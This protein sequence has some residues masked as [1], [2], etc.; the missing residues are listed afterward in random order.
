MNKTILG[1]VY[2]AGLL[3]IA[4]CNSAEPPTATQRLS[5]AQF[6]ELY[7]SLRNAQDSARTSAEFDALKQ[8]ILE[9]AGATSESLSQ[10]AIEHTGQIAFMAEV[11]DSI[12]TRLDN[13][14]LGTPR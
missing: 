13:A 9:R 10:F 4:G 7:V 12:R 3:L 5:R 11:W 6:I 2:L 8:Q 1:L 14:A